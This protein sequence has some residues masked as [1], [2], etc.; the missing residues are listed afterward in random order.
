[1]VIIGDAPPHVGEGGKCEELAKSAAAKG[2][3][4]YTIQ[5]HAAEN[6]KDVKWFPE[7]SLAG[8]GRSVRLGDEDSLIAEI[9]QLTLGDRFHDELG[10]FFTVYRALCR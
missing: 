5:A 8:G 1:M 4:I 3:R 7:I 9:A 2:M 6:A 10:E